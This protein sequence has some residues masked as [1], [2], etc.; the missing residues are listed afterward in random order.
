MTETE[1]SFS[2]AEQKPPLIAPATPR[3]FV[4]K[5][6]DAAKE[7]ATSL[8]ASVETATANVEQALMNAV[9]EGAKWTRRTQQAAHEDAEAFLFGVDQLASAKS[10][11]AAVQIYIDYMRGR[12]DITISR[13]RAASDYLGKLLVDGAKTLQ[14]N[15]ATT[16]V[17]SRKAA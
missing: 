10:V 3:D 5:A 4:R 6:A 7:R 14:D 8:H 16:G 2:T 15:V 17:F 9:G 13:T 11:G 12:G 1:K